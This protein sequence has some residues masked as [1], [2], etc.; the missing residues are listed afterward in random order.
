VEISGVPSRM[1]YT[2]ARTV[3]ERRPAVVTRSG[4]STWSRPNAC[5]VMSVKRCVW[6]ALSVSRIAGESGAQGS[7]TA[8]SRSRPVSLTISTSVFQ[9]T[10][11]APN[12]LPTTGTIAVDTS[13]AAAVPAS[14][15][16]T[17]S[18]R[19]FIPSYDVRD[20]V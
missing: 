8:T 13:C 4:E 17:R 16:T 19:H 3:T 5:A 11:V 9:C 14:S 18:P 15:S 1:P 12:T 2:L 20:Y 6:P 7:S 10:M